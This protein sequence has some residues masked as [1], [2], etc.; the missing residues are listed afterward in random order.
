MSSA[1]SS[2]GQDGVAPLA[3]GPAPQPPSNPAGGSGRADGSRR[4]GQAPAAPDVTAG[5]G[6]AGGLFGHRDF[7]LAFAAA[8]VS[9]LGTQISYLAVPL[10]AVTTLHA[11]PGELGVLNALST[12]AFLLIGL[13]AG[14]W[15]DRTRQRRLQIVTD[16]VR[17][18]LLL[19]V[20]LAW[21]AGALTLWQLYVV[22]L[23]TGV[24]TVFF[25]VANQSFLPHLVGRDRLAEAN[26]RLVSLD[27]A[28]Q[29]AGRSLGGYLVQLLTAPLAIALDAITYVWSAV[30]LILIRTSD[31]VPARRPGRRLYQE[32]GE[33]LRFVFGDRLL[34]PLVLEAGLTNFAIQVYVTM[35][36]VLFV[37]ELGLSEGALG[38]FLALGGVGVFLGSM[39]ARPLSARLGDARVMWVMGPLIAPAGF[40]VPLADHGP[41]VWLAGA[42]WLVIT[43]KAGVDNVLKVSFRQRIT[44]DHLLGRMNATFRFLMFGALALGALLAG[45]LGELAGVRAAMWA[46]SAVLA[47]GWLRL[48]FSPLRSMRELPA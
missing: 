17:A 6:A 35:L 41:G 27:A 22:V 48:F 11:S 4:G 23:F 28:N 29:V 46:G 1:S 34:N 40:L 20:P 39:L 21:W 9:K 3:D 10:L 7:R 24:A 44:P 8:A 18:A 15:V 36:P 12:I 19:S 47:A 37:R 26:A 14:A 32:I 25:D 33:G 13:P 38:F 16:L 43:A 45:A 30:C 2:S 42:A 5:S 31:P